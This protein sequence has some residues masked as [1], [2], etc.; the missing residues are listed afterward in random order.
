MHQR[1]SMWLV[2]ELAIGSV[3][4]VD[5]AGRQAA[6]SGESARAVFAET[7]YEFGIVSQG[8]KL[9]HAFKLHNEGTTPLAISSVD[10]KE[11]GM[12]ARF[13]PAIAPGQAAQ[14]TIEWDTSQLQGLVEGRAV[15]NIS[16]NTCPRVELALIGSVL[17]TRRQGPA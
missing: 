3:A 13:T 12:K 16:D 9:S 11:P 2:A 8:V 7:R 10:L 6:A 14:I 4:A 17:R 15:V 5:G 1:A